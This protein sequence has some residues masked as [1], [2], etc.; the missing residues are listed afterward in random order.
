MKKSLFI[1]LLAICSINI[2]SQDVKK[3]KDFLAANSL[4]KAKESIDQTLANTKNQKDAEAWYTKGKV[5]GAI[6][7][8]DA[9]KSLAPDGRMEALDAFKKALEIDKN[10]TT[11][12]LTVDKYQPVFGLYTGFFDEAAA[13]YNAEKFQDALVN[14]KKAGVVGDYIFSQGW[15][16]YKLDTVLTYYSALSAMN[17][18]NDEEAVVQFQ[19]LADARV[20]VTPEHATSYRWLAKHYYDKKDEAN[21]MKYINLGKE[22]YPKDEYLPLLELDYVRNKG[23]KAALMAKYEE[24]MKATPENYDLLMEYANELFGET[25]VTDASK[26]PANYTQNL[27]KIEGL[28]KKAI[29][30][31]PESLD[32][33]LSLGKHYYNQALFIEEDMSKIKG[34]KPEDKQKKDALNTQLVGVC[35]KAIPPLE[36]VFNEYDAKGKLKVSEKSNYKSA[37][38]LLV[39]CYDKK[40]DKA[41]SDFYDKKY[42]GADAAH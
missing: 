12:Y 16:L 1:C 7:A 33:N 29:E 34:T 9:H 20:A 35:D 26:R 37:C 40:K 31:K 19:K 23:D 21:M 24:L 14:F 39:Y 11:L 10:Q 18:K 22:L 15:G 42:S 2:Y 6:A 36:K 30:V 38:N 27:D 5:Y 17:A 4:D 13:Q 25:H 8:S 28:Y 32:A 41:K 3:A